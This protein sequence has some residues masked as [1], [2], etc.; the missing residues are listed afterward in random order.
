[1]TV[2]V[3]IAPVTVLNLE[4]LNGIKKQA[5]AHRNWVAMGD[6]V[7]RNNES[8]RPFFL[9]CYF[10]ILFFLTYRTGAF[11]LST[12]FVNDQHFGRPW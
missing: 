1:M 7:T 4:R 5:I 2:R 11:A 6:D 10:A 9:Q 12:P 8:F 3:Q